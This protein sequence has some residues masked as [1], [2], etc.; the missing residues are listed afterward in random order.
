MIGCDGCDDWF[1]GECVH[2]RQ[3]DED[4]VDQYFCKK[5]SNLF[6]LFIHEA[7]LLRSQ[8]RPANNGD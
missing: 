1:H 8:V 3:E 5:L 7:N 2:L 4:L 6:Y